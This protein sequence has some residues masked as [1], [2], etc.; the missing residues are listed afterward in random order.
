M[1]ERDLEWTAMD[2]Y[3]WKKYL[4]KLETNDEL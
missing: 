4:E 3:M 2:E 1:D